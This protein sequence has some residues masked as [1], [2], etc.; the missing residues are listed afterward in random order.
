[1]GR[2]VER[3]LFTAGVAGLLWC[4]AV[5][6]QAA[7][8]DRSVRAGLR[9]T[10]VAPAP[11]SAL[12]PHEPLSGLVEIPRLGM[13]EAIAEGDDDQTM[14][15]AVGHLPDTPDP[16]AP[17]NTALAGHRDSFFRALRDI[18]IGD[19]VRVDTRHGDFQYH[20]VATRI[21]KPADVWVLD[22]SA[23]SPHRLTLIT[24]YPFSYT[25]HAPRRFVVVADAAP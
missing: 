24:C 7:R 12:N 21:V 19:E 6:L 9:A 8:Y 10:P 1:M 5:Y 14:R 18:R 15:Y 17:G 2:I 25:G 23:D 16:W 13:S 22:A 11:V 20:V 3:V 4:G